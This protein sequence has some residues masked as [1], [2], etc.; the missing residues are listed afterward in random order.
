MNPCFKETLVFLSSPGLF[1]QANATPISVMQP[2]TVIREQM[3][4]QLV[5]ESGGKERVKVSQYSG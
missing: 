2:T 3:A 1:F 5:M 4:G